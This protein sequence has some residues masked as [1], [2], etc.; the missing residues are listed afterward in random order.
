[1][2]RGRTGFLLGIAL[3][4]AFAGHTFAQTESISV[5]W[6][7]GPV[8]GASLGEWTARWWRWAQNAPIEPYR[9]PDGRLCDMNQAGPVWFLAGTDG[10]FE[11][12][13]RCVV[14]EGKY[15]LLPVINMIYWQRTDV[16]KRMP[17]AELQRGSAVNNDHLVSAVVVLDGKPLGEMRVH[18]V[19]SDGCFALNPED[20]SSPLAAADGYWLMLKPLS[21]GHHTL[22]VGA[23]YGAP[24]QVYGNMAQ[25]FEYELDVGGRTLL[26]MREESSPLR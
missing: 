26:G 2:R 8:E 6:V 4:G 21:R 5:P 24:E 16:R 17:C 11:P 12:R 13:R 22:S 18:R 19:R 9:D 7:D 10:T 14:P 20:A 3:A 23:N 15:L 1:M 25:N